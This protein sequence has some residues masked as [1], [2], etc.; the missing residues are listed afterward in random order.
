MHRPDNKLTLAWIAQFRSPAEVQAHAEETFH[1][2]FE[3]STEQVALSAACQQE[4]RIQPTH[5]VSSWFA[6]SENRL[7]GVRKA[8]QEPG[9]A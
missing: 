4:I 3:E 1:T 5:G 2:N 7:Q 6:D 9:G 8:M